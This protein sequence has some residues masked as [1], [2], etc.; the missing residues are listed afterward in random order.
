MDRTHRQRSELDPA[1]RP[2]AHGPA[3]PR[4]ELARLGSPLGNEQ[5]HALAAQATGGVPQ[6]A[7]GRGVEPLRVIDGHE[8][9]PAPA[10]REDDAE[11]RHGNRALLGTRTVRVRQ[12]Q[13]H[14][15]RTTL[16]RRQGRQHVID[17]VRE[18]ICERRERHAR[19]R[20][21]GRRL[22]DREAATDCGGDPGCHNVVLPAPGSP[23]S[24][25]VAEAPHASSRNSVSA[26]SSASLP[27]I[28][29]DDTAR[30]NLS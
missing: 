18:Q 19:L 10:E 7:G 15:E 11:E 12:E 30:E 5:P 3:I 13:R 22:Q 17:H 29:A 16:R 25:S 21:R 27:M 28:A 2:S 4:R 20:R 8:H 6:D 14:L 23:E 1:T 9:G 24:T 26:E